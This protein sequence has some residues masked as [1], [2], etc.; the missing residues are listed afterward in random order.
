[1][2]A[3]AARGPVLEDAARLVA[4]HALRAYDAVQLASARAARQADAGLRTAAAN[5]GFSLLG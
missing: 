5:E 1:M 2:V 4:T 3:V